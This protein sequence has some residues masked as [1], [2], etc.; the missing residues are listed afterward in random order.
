MTGRLTSSIYVSSII[1]RVNVSGGFAAV[2]RRGADDAG[3][4]FICVP[5]AG[6]GTALYAQVPQSVMADREDAPSGGRLFE[7]IGE[8]LSEED[9]STRFDKEARLDPDFWVLEI[10]LF[11]RKPEDFFDIA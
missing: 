5:D 1:R 10:E 8:T 3:A 4:I 11:G 9:L 7:R 2:I 6:G